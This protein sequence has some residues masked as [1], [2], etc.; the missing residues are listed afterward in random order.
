MKR[1]ITMTE[2]ELDRVKLMQ[3]AEEKRFT[4]REGAIRLEI[5][6]NVIFDDYCND[7]GREG[8]KD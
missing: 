3:M 8:I 5:T 4:Q 2:Q 6:V 1:T 7:I